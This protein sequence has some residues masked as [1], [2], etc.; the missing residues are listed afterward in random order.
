[1]KYT[2][3]KDPEMLQKTYDFFTKQAG[4]N[5]D[6]TITDQGIAQILNFL[7]STVLPA[8]KGASPKQ[9]YDTRISEQMA[10]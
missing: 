5:E 2:K 6:L 9:F 1:M 7:A 10:K 3:E 4:F 8:A